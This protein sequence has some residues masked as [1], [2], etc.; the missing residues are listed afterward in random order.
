MYNPF[1]LQYLTGYKPT[2]KELEEA[3]QAIKGW[4]ETMESLHGMK[5]P[6]DLKE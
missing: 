4:I 2:K 3:E 5:F 1:I 6:K